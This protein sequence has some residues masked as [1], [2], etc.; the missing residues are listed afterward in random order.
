MNRQAKRD[1]EHGTTVQTWE[2]VVQGL[3]PGTFTIPA[4]S[5]RFFDTNSRQYKTLKT[6]PLTI[7]VTPSTRG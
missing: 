4:Q 7:T 3:K 6:E 5:I 2:Y 1:A